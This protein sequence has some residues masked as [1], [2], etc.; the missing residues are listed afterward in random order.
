LPDVIKISVGVPFKK[1]QHPF[2]FLF[3]L[4]DAIAVRNERFRE[5]EVEI[6]IECDKATCPY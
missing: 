1:P 5:K 2:I 6:G 3:N 4:T